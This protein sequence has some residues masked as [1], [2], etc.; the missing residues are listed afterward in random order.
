MKISLRRSFLGQSI[1]AAALL[2][3]SLRP[4]TSR[5]DES[6]KAGELT[7]K[8]VGFLR[9]RQAANGSW[10]NGTSRF[11]EGDANLVTAYG[12]LALA[13]ARQKA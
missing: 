6:A 5:T 2:G 13:H 7:A 3:L 10:V 9:S 11:M 8:A 4:P 1:P 12:L